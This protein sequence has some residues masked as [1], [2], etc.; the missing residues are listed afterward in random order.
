MNNLLVVVPYKLCSNTTRALLGCNLN[1]SEILIES[2]SVDDIASLVILFIY[3]NGLLN[4]WKMNPE[5][6]P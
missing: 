1:S 5:L 2:T 6:Y 4:H 3:L